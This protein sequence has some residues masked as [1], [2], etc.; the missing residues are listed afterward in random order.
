VNTNPAVVF[1]NVSKVY[2][3]AAGR[4]LLRGHLAHLFSRSKSREPFYALRNVSFR[5]DHCESVA[6]IGPN[7]A[8]KS[9]LLSMVAGLSFPSE[10]NVK[11]DG[12]VAA[13]LELGTGFH[14]DLTGS[15][16]IHLNASLLGLSKKRTEYLFDS[17]VDFSGIGDF[18]EEP[19]RTYSTGMMMRLAFAVAVNVDPDILILDEVFA[20]GD[21]NFQAKCRDKVLEFKKSGKT[22][23]C[24]SHATATIHELC[25]RAIW[26][27]HGELVMDGAAD[28][29]VGLYSGQM[30]A[31]R[32]SEMEA[33]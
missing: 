22:M 10:G 27:D 16:N 15:E 30:A 4:R 2:S 32:E 18:I 7:G 5:L 28:E 23:L 13:L 3:R 12:R 24:V 8:G 31:A 17:I 6:I 26:L 11:I 9:T 1:E 33:K 21:Q 14:P 19:L 29:V 25:D 20:V